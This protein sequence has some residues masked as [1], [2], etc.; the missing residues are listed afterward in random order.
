MLCPCCGYEMKLGARA[1]SCGARIVGELDLEPIRKVQRLGPSMLALSLFM[2]VALAAAVWTLWAATAGLLVILSARRAVI[3]GRRDR[4]GYGG[5]GVATAVLVATSISGAALAG[6]AI[7]RIPLALHKR[8]L[9]QEAATTAAFYELANVLADYKTKKGFY[10]GN[11][12]ELKKFSGRSLPK[13]YWDRTISYEGRMDAIAE[14]NLGRGSRRVGSVGGLQFNGFELRSA[15]P[16]GIAGTADDIMM[17][18]G[19]FYTSAEVIEK[20]LVR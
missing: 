15:G 8:Q 12:E 16:D 10:P 18:D 4:E 2:V 9:A 3:L 6:Y 17:R 7:G 20:P 14:A 19:V 5:L 11:D 13:D 1:C